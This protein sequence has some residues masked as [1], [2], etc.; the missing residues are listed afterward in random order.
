[1]AGKKILKIVLNIISKVVNAILG[2]ASVFA[3][4]VKKGSTLKGKSLLP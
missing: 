1:M 3:S 4:H 2:E